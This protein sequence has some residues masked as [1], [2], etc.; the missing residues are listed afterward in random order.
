MVV[1]VSV[2][3]G[4]GPGVG[5]TFG[6]A[7]GDS[8]GLLV[9]RVVGIAVAT[10]TFVMQRHLGAVQTPF[11]YTWVWVTLAVWYSHWPWRAS[12]SMARQALVARQVR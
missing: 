2:G 9:G 6:L 3:D 1:G 8:E 11:A 12:N 4:E 7:V 10:A 5:V